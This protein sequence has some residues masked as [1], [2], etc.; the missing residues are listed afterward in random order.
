MIKMNLSLFESAMLHEP[1]S[2]EMQGLRLF[3]CCCIPT[4]YPQTL[5]FPY[6]RKTAMRSILRF[7]QRANE[8]FHLGCRVLRHPIA[9]VTVGVE[10]EGDGCV[11]EGQGKRL[12]VDFALNGKRGIGVAN[13]VKANFR[14]IELADQCLEMNIQRLETDEHAVVTSENHVVHIVP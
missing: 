11:S 5:S 3:L 8:L 12:K 2:L 6:P 7:L 9:D 4:P 13:I 1:K 10:R 14:A